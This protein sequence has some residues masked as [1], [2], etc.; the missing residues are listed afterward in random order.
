[1]TGLVK[2]NNFVLKVLG[3]SVGSAINKFA[4]IPV[5]NGAAMDVP[6]ILA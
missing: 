5:T 3:V 2:V 1:M 6:D 4:A